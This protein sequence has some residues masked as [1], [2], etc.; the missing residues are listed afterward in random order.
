M[1][2]RHAIPSISGTDHGS[3]LVHRNRSLLGHGYTWL[4]AATHR[5]YLLSIHEILTKCDQ[6]QLSG[7]G[8]FMGVFPKLS[9]QL[10][11]C[12]PLF[13]HLSCLRARARKNGDNSGQLG[14]QPTKSCPLYL[15]FTVS[16]LILKLMP[17]LFSGKFLM[18]TNV[19][20]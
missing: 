5:P 3:R 13:A 6:E 7:T 15:P 11:Y 10:P 12:A 4:Y 19:P 20:C 1:V 16:S 9:Q 8:S 18:S 17:V 2:A 14:R